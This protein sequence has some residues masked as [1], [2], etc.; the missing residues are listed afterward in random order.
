MGPSRAIC[1]GVRN[2]LETFPADLGQE[3]VYTLDWPPA[4]SNMWP[5]NDHILY[6]QQVR[7]SMPTTYYDKAE[8]LHVLALIGREKQ[9]IPFF[10]FPFYVVKLFKYKKKSIIF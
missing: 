2:E 1:A 6:W 8:Q 3:V 10:V 9:S 7:L 5:E 4:I